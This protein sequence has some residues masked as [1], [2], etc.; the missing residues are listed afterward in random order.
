MKKIWLGLVASCLVLLVVDSA[1]ADHRH[2]NN[3]RSYGG[4]SRS[5]GYGGYGGY[6]GYRGHHHGHTHY[7][8]RPYSSYYNQGFYGYPTY[9]PGYLNYNSYGRGYGGSRFGIYIG[10]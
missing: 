3:C 10:F 5:Y 8:Y 7:S 6:S 9:G 1:K 2:R 4:Y